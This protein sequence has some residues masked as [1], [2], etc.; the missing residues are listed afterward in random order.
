LR[1]P[2]PSLTSPTTD[3]DTTME[4]RRQTSARDG[5]GFD[6]L[7]GDRDVEDVAVI[8]VPTVDLGEEVKA[9]VQ[10]RPDLSPGSEIAN[11]LID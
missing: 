7:I 5:H 1:R 8:G 4:L 9:V 3:G 11:V 10:L 6:C 2:L